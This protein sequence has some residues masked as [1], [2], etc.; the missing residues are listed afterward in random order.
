[1]AVA[2][3]APRAPGPARAT[4]G[5]PASQRDTLA[6]TIEAVAFT[7]DE[8]D[9]GITM[10]FG[11]FLGKGSTFFVNGD[12]GTMGVA[13]AQRSLSGQGGRREHRPV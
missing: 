2:A 12:Q 13:L 1:M 5:C 8:T 9:H 10:R 6:R 11:C 3:V 4:H 7:K